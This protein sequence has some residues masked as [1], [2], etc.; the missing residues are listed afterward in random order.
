MLQK[1]QSDSKENEKSNSFW[2]K[3]FQSVIFLLQFIVCLQI[4]KMSSEEKQ[5]FI[6]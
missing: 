1:T 6:T 5:T 3:D 2:D 4:N